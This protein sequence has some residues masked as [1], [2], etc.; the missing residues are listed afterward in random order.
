MALEIVWAEEAEI[1]LDEIIIYLEENWSEREIRN[2]FK[3][4]EQGIEAIS[5]SPA[6]HKI[7]ARKSNTREYQLSPQTTIFYTFDYK[8]VVIL[9]LWPNKKNPKNLK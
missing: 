1:Q 3:S 8:Q 2:F 7:S 5:K 4:L 6:T 9:L